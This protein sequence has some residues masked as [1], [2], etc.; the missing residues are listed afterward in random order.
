MAADSPTPDVATAFF[1][2]H[3]LVEGGTD[4]LILLLRNF[5]ARFPGVPLVVFEVV[6]PE[7]EELRRRP[8]MSVHY[9]LYHDLT[10]QRPMTQQEWRD[11][12][13]AAGFP[14]VAERYLRFART[15]VYT[16][17]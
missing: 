13:R 6:R 11:V 15:T 3:D 5:R 7:L 2:L 16:L 9:F 14:S 17:V 4:R 12:F 8:G 1:V 10:Q